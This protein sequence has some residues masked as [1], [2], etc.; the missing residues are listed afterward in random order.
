LHRVDEAALQLREDSPREP[1]L[2]SD[3]ERYQ[4]AAAQKSLKLLS[5]ELGD[6]P[7][8][9][10][11]LLQERLPMFG[12]DPVKLSLFRLSAFVGWSCNAH[13][14]AVMECGASG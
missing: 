10:G 14:L 11:S 6:I 4:Y 8:L 7:P 13:P 5:D 2:T 1:E 9:E 12:D 3:G